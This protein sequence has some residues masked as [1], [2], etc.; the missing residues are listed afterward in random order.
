MSLYLNK[1]LKREKM[2][3]ISLIAIVFFIVFNLYDEEKM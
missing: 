1:I 3:K 2:K